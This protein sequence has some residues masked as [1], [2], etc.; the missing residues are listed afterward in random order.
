MERKEERLG[1]AAVKYVRFNGLAEVKRLRIA[2]YRMAFGGNRKYAMHPAHVLVQRLHERTGEWETVADIETPPP[3]GDAPFECDLAGACVRVDLLRVVCDRKHVMAAVHGNWWVNPEIVPFAILDDFTFLGMTVGSGNEPAYNPP[4][5]LGNYNPAALEGQT[6]VREPHQVT[7]GSPFFTV[8]FSLR[9]PMIVHLG[10]DDMGLGSSTD[11]LLPTGSIWPDGQSYCGPLLRTLREDINA[12]YWTGEVR[13]EGNRITYSGLR[14][15]EDSVTEISFEAGLRGMNIRIDKTCL[16]DTHALEA[17][18]WRFVWDGRRT[19]TGTLGLP[20]REN[21]RTGQ[22]R[23]PAMWNAPGY[24]TLGIRATGGSTEPVMQVDAW[25]ARGIGWA[26]ISAGWTRDAYG[27]LTMKAGRYSAELTLEVSPL[28][29]RARKEADAGAE[30]GETATGSA[31]RPYPGIGEAAAGSTDRSHPGIYRNWSGGFGFRPELAGFSNNALSCNCHLSQYH[32][33]DMAVY[34]GTDDPYPSMGELLR[35]TL[36][37]SLKEGPGYGDGYIDNDPS[38]LI[39]LGR[40]Q[41][42]EP[43]A[44]WIRAMWPHIRRTTQRMLD[45]IDDGGLY[46][47]RELTGN[48]GSKNWS[49]NGW[50]VVGFGHYDAYGNAQIYRALMNMSA[51]AA[52]AGEEHYA[53][54]CRRASAGLKAA[55]GQSFLNPATGW[56]AG[57]KSE[58]GRLHDYAFTFINFMA[59]CYGLVEGRMARTIIDKLE[60]RMREMG[61]T[62]YYYGLPANLIS[63]RNEDAPTGND[64]KRT[65]GLDR[66]GVYVN[67]CLTTQWVNYYLR[68]LS[69]YGY[70]DKADLVCDHL[71]QYFATRHA[72]GGL[73]AGTE[74]RTWEGRACG[75]EGVLVGSY[76]VLAAMAQHRGII[77]APSQEWWLGAP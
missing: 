66:Y 62:Y 30:E 20:V 47:C 24:G 56:L 35:Y 40:V 70:A 52:I 76:P 39:A 16:R 23:L 53:E 69:M 12:A 77:E 28:R 59:I 3:D 5:R 22:V 19:V 67:G 11:N 43:D 36:E 63:I 74:F 29:P 26:G 60:D 1:L 58:D 42:A 25:R 45:G 61:L 9:R 46:V 50:D 7:F 6:L 73:G 54:T 27:A 48:T 14:A 71:E 17:D 57:W 8:G 15:G 10:W 13:V 49:S 44:E 38:I 2:P 65:D 51:I 55:Y 32:A 31:G 34:T 37:V 41:D 64:Y 4:L 21:G 75:Y 18:D 68:A 72:S 33:A